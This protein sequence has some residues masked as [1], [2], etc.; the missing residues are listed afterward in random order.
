MLR[1]LVLALA[2]GVGL[3]TPHAAAHPPA[4]HPAL[5]KPVWRSRLLRRL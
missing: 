4:R 2:V 1:M 5:R 3:M